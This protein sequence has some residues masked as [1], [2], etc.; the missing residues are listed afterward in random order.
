MLNILLKFGLV[1][2]L[3]NIEKISANKVNS[4]IVKQ[5]HNKSTQCDICGATISWFNKPRHIKSKKHSDVVYIQYS[6][7]EM[8]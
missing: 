4:N 8:K 1:K 6:K 5:K 3:E 2:T 7:F